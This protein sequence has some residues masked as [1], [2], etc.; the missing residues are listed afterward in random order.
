MRTSSILV[1]AIVVVV[2]VVQSNV[3]AAVFEIPLACQGQ[4]DA[5]QTWT[6]DFDLGVS[7]T[8]ISSI[9]IDWSGSITA[10]L[11]ALVDDP[12]VT[13]P[14]DAQFVAN[15][16]DLSS[17]DFCGAAYVVGGEATYPLPDP[18]DLQS[19]FSNNA[20]SKLLGGQGTVEIG[21][22][23]TI[24]PAIYYTV[25]PPSGQIQS[26]TLVLEGTPVPEPITLLLL[27]AGAI[28][29]LRKRT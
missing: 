18:F 2:L 13:L 1:F 10:E 22:W 6:T 24:L 19:A 27:G 26:A 11:I 8:Q 12:Y 16:Y 28:A 21:F 29:L 20:W 14:W 17:H 7:F 15:L 5:G 4:Y 9:Y 25:E 3:H 23:G